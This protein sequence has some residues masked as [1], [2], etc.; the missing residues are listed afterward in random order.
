D[1]VEAARICNK[2]LDSG[3]VIGNT[4]CLIGAIAIAREIEI[5]TIDQEFQKLTSI[6]KV[7]LYQP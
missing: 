7:P 6:V 1:F 3:I 2:C 4:T 5:L